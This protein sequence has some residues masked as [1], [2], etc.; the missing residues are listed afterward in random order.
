MQDISKAKTIQVEWSADKTKLWVNQEGGCL[1][2]IQNIEKLLLGP[3]GLRGELLDQINTCYEI[4]VRNNQ[5][6]LPS[7]MSQV[8]AQEQISGMFKIL[9]ILYP[10]QTKE[11]RTLEIKYELQLNKAIIKD[12]I[13]ANGRVERMSGSYIVCP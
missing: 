11:L 3:E 2:R 8:I 9:R 10:E 4:I 7:P 5:M 6:T 12:L 1:L 13:D